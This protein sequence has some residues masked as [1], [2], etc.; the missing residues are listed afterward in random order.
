MVTINWTLEAEANLKKLFTIV[1]LDKPKA[2]KKLIKSIK[3]RTAILKVFPRS[4]NRLYEYETLEIRVLQYG[5][6]KIIYRVNSVN[7]LDILSVFNDAFPLN[8]Y[9]VDFE[10]T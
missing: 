4:G 7:S 8:S 9:F 5:H 10:V 1:S 2:A 3:S 6:Y